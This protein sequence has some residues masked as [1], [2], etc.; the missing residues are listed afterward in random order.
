M[1]TLLANDWWQGWNP[2]SVWLAALIAGVLAALIYCL[3]VIGLYIRRLGRVGK[4]PP[5]AHKAEKRK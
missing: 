3:I 2:L 1:I 4:V 5:H